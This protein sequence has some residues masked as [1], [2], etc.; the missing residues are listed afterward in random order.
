MTTSTQPETGTSTPTARRAV[1]T[2]LL[3]RDG[4]HPGAAREGDADRRAATADAVHSTVFGEW[5]TIAQTAERAGVDALFIADSPA[6]GPEASPHLLATPD[7]V[8]N[9]VATFTALRTVVEQTK[10]TV[11]ELLVKASGGNRHREFVGTP[12]SFAADV[13]S[14]IRSGAADGFTLLLPSTR[15]DLPYFADHV[16]L[17]LRGSGAIP[18]RYA[19]GDLRRQLGLR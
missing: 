14:W 17:V 13:D 11:R 1:T 10:P 19:D 15:R 4:V 9:S 8:D 2:L 3:T 12:A 18:Q 16:S 5:A 6:V 7:Q